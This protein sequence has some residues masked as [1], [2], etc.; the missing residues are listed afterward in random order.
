LSELREQFNLLSVD[1]L[2]KAA[3]VKG[4]QTILYWVRSSQNQEFENIE[5]LNTIAQA[6]ASQSESSQAGPSGDSPTEQDWIVR[7]VCPKL[8]PLVN[9]FREVFRNDLPKGLP[10]ERALDHRIDTGNS[11]PVNRPPYAL[12]VSQ[13]EEQKRQIA[14]LLDRGLI[15]ESISPWGSP[16]L[17]VTKPRSPGEWR[18]CIDY[19]MLNK[20]TIRNTYPLPRIEDCINRLGNAKHLTTLD[21]TSGYWQ[22]RVAPQDIPKTAFNTRYG[23]YEFLVM[24]FGLTNAPSTF[25]ML[26]NQILRPYIDKFV[27]V[28]L[29]DIMVYSNSL[30]EH[31]HHLRLV[32]EAL[33][34]ANLY[35]KPKKCVF[36]KP[37]VEFCGHIVGS[38]VVKVLDQKVKVIRD[39]P[40]PKNVHEV[41]QFYGLAN[42]YRRFIKHFAAIAAPLSELFKT[43]DKES[44]KRNKRRPIVWN[45][46]CQIAFNRLKDALSNAPVLAQPD[47]SK[48]Y[49]IETD[50][51]DFAIGYA[52]MQKGDD[53]QIHPIAYEGSKLSNAELKYPVHEK[54][55]LAVKRALEKWSHYI[56]NGQTTT[57]LTDHESLK[58]MNTVKT[59]SRRLARWVDA[60][61]SY[62]IDIQYRR[63]TEAIVPDALS[64]RPDWLNLIL[65]YDDII[66]ALEAFLKDRKLPHDHELRQRVLK[67]V[68][69]FTIQNDQVHR[70]LPGGE[71]VPYIDP[72]F[73]GDFMDKMHHQFGHL[74]YAGMIHA[75]ESRAWW[76]AMQS[77][78]REFIASCPNCQVMQR[79]RSHQEKEMAQIVTDPYIQP[80]QRWGIDLIGLLP[81]TKK[82]N[83]WIITA[84][85][86]ATG[87]PVAK[88]VPKATDEAIADFIFNEIY[89]HY[90][91]PH[92]LFSDGGKNL[93]SGVVQAFLKRIG[94][95]HKGSSPY[96]PRT[97]GKV[98]RLNGIL[99]GMISRLLF[100][101]PTKLWDEYLDQALFACR[102]RTNQ[103]TKQSPFY[104]L[105]GQQPHLLGDT[106]L[107]RPANAEVA[108]PMD[109]I[110]KIWAARREAVLATYQR[111][112]KEQ[113]QR[114]DL[115]TPHALDSGEWVLVRHENPQKFESKW[116]G[117]YQIVEKK[118]LGTYRLQDPSGKELAALIHGNRLVQANIRTTDALRKLWA[119]PS[120]KDALRR[121][122]ANLELVPSDPENTRILE[123]H[124]MDLDDQPDELEPLIHDLDA[125][126]NTNTTSVQSSRK[127]SR[128]DANLPE[129]SPDQ[130]LKLRIP[131]RLWQEQIALQ[132][133]EDTSF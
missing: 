18:M 71:I 38:G 114:N 81:K 80:F 52:L 20:A 55:L 129:L 92:E 95:N 32:F 115:V 89:M 63:G 28:Y 104:L 86:Y 60:F 99:G 125:D 93:W 130:P 102:I 29:D 122:N 73:R 58:Y 76:P 98:E 123:R 6:S 70:K 65:Q 120:V 106:H 121:Q 110:P 46:A 4:A 33:R 14:D 85:D 50:A 118:L 111:A 27:L 12:S 1:E 37:E 53:D 74:T 11:A 101:K 108:D 113:G 131:L 82:G 77:D 40:V 34:D 132:Q 103:T 75:V 57:I 22:M 54:E 24:P 124:L 67:E 15:R 43:V 83:R 36:N 10:P 96:H 97:N 49:I 17:F 39:W 87:W 45:T 35:A 44:D 84:I 2:D 79:Q 25:Q 9:E 59:P 13:L 133:V 100:G 23:K 7:D 8:Q 47:P 56:E 117:P 69:D 109:R 119:S 90:G 31:K 42:Y 66:A 72:L 19:R 94:T 127:R 91:A 26:M 128:Q 41:R 88:A 105:Y 78:L 68:N 61:Q 21:L 64:R 48:P 126:A 51:S 16:V 107:A 62:K 116:F 3:K 5:A 112:V 30:D